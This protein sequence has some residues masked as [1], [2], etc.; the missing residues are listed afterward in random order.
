MIYFEEMCILTYFYVKWSS[1]F[2]FRGNH[3][4]PLIIDIR[5]IAIYE[6]IITYI[7]EQKYQFHPEFLLD[8]FECWFLTSGWSI[9]S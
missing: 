4:Y 3:L 6:F 1:K 8:K 9:L 5:A 2:S 7:C